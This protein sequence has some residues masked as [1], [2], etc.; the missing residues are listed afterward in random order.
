ML[1]YSEAMTT[2]Q[3]ALLGREAAAVSGS[4][5]SH[6][7]EHTGMERLQEVMGRMD[8]DDDGGRALLKKLLLHGLA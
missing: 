3:R 5:S 7:P 6:W 2:R 1:V 4:S 8:G